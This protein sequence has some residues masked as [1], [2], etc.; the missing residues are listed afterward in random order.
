MNKFKVMLTIMVVGL[1]AAVE[2]RAAVESA[3]ASLPGL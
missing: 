1:M 3:P 2:G